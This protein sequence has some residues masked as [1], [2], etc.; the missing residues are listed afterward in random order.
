MMG[1]L[2]AGQ[3]ELFY[4]FCIEKHVPP[5]HILRGIEQFLDFDAIR[6]HLRAL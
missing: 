6:E 4:E 5:S 3:N 1:R 2:L